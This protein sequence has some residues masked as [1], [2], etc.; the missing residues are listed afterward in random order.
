M[1]SDGVTIGGLVDCQPVR[2]LLP[3]Q[4]RRRAII[5]PLHGPHPTTVGKKTAINPTKSR[6]CERPD[7]SEYSRIGGRQL[8]LVGAVRH[9][10][11]D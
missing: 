8:A 1:G 2:Q 10:G 9:E 11:G 6:S 3:L 7:P 5:L 4:D